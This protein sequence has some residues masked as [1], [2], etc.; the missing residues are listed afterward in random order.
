MSDD[1]WISKADC[2]AIRAFVS[3]VHVPVIISGVDGAIFWANDE[4]C[5]WCGYS[6][7]E[8]RQSGWRKLSVANED[9]AV[10]IASAGE[11]GGYR[12]TYSIQKQ[13]VPKNDKPHWGTLSL[14]RYPATGPIEYCFCT[15]VAHKNG[16]Q[17]AFDM[18]M[19]ELGKLT[20]QVEGNRI[21][22][23]KLNAATTEDVFMSAGVKLLKQNPK[24]AWAIFIIVLGIFGF[25]NVLQI[26]TGLNLIPHA[27]SVTPAK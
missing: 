16:T 17:T 1:K 3:N 21:E 7:Q 19:K 22:I 2:E 20:T 23:A 5:E 25:N 14:M 26:V 6:V 4:F 8:L 12:L 18:A 15:W 13:Y 24:V 27:T 10:D 9:F 11:F